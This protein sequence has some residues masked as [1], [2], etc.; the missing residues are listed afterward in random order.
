MTRLDED[1]TTSPHCSPAACAIA[2]LAT[3]DLLARARVS[4]ASRDVSDAMV[5]D[6]LLE[7][8]T[9]A[10]GQPVGPEQWIQWYRKSAERLAAKLE[11]RRR[12]LRA[13]VRT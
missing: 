9:A 2:N 12:E 8:V 1:Y 7:K 6:G 11:P 3:A 10:I 5:S 13:G 4:W